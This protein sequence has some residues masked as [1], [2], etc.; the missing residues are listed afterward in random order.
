MNITSKMSPKKQTRTSLR[1]AEGLNKKGENVPMATD[2][3]E[4][5]VLKSLN[6]LSYLKSKFSDQDMSDKIRK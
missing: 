5:L 3:N 6:N 1:L 4:W 2:K